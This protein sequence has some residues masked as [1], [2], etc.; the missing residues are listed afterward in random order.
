MHGLPAD[1]DLSFLAGR[2]LTQLGVGSNEAILYFDVG[3]TWIRIDGRSSVEAAAS[4]TASDDSRE[5]APAM[6]PLIGQSVTDVAWQ[7]SGTIRLTFDDGTTLVIEDDS[8]HYESYQIVHG[9]L[10][11]TV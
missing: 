11:I 2:T 3:Q 8:P 1:A 10:Q 4:T 6:F 9:N 5:I 7:R